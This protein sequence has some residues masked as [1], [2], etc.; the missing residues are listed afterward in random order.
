[1][2]KGTVI[3][4]SLGDKNILKKIQI[5]KTWKDGDWIRHSVQ[6][7]ENE[8]LRIRGKGVPQGR[9]RGDALVRVHIVLPRKLSRDAKKKI[10]KLKKE[11]V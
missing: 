2:L 9:H 5:D 8:L 4:N 7:D 1:M 6:V 11:G 10:E 3:E